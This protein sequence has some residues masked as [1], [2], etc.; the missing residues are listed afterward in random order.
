MIEDQAKGKAK[1]ESKGL[2]RMWLSPIR[3]CRGCFVSVHFDRDQEEGV[4]PLQ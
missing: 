2:T 4:Q 1:Q 3:Q